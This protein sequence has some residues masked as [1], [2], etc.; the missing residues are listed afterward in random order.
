[1]ATTRPI[2]T[3]FKAVKSSEIEHETV[4][5][6]EAEAMEFENSYREILSSV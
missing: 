1:M 3:F 6:A 5:E 2:I 4:V